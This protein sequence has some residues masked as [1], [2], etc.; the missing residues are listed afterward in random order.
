MRHL[1]PPRQADGRKGDHGRVVVAGGSERY[2]G[3]P[4]FN[5]LAALRAGADLATV[6]APRRAADIVATFSPDLITIPCDTAWPDARRVAEVSA[7]ALVIGGGIER[8]EEA[9]AA[10]RAIVAAFRGPIVLDAEA[11]Y[12]I[13]GKPD[14]LAG[15]AALLTPH[16]GEAKVLGAS[17][18]RELATRY[19]STAIVKGALD[20]VSDGERNAVDEAGSPFLTKGGYGDLLAGAAGALLARGV[21]PFEAARGAAWLVGT[22]GARAAARLGEATLASDALAEFG[23]VLT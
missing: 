23:N 2:S 5:A 21:K 9:H 10:I 8:T 6:V 14:V 3:A 22:A 12:A 11:L 17:T 20:A 19:H 15:K 13:A 4:A 1:W 16:P 7:D 18:A